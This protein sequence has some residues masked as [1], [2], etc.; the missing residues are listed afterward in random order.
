MHDCA[1]APGATFL[2]TSCPST[3][4]SS[5][6]ARTL[7]LPPP[8]PTPGAPRRLTFGAVG[9]RAPGGEEGEGA[10]FGELIE[11]RF[12]DGEGGVYKPKEGFEAG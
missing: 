10:R 3:H 5:N 11:D 8:T 2:P 4:S 12:E 7:P 9:A 6:S 1:G